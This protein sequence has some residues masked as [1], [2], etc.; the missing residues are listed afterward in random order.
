MNA[1]DDSM[2]THRQLETLGYAFQRGAAEA[3]AALGRWLERPSLITVDS[4]EQLLLRDATELL[5][6]GED[7]ICFCSA[8]LAGRLTGELILAFD[9]A[10]GL[11]LAD[12]LLNQPRGTACLWGEMETSAALETANIVGCAYSECAGQSVARRAAGFVRAL[13]HS[14]PFS[15]RLCG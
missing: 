8:E 2:L 11:A 1:Q 5:G 10:S 13:T 7:P 4:V 6:V 3:S 12:M 14:P 15:S 9:E